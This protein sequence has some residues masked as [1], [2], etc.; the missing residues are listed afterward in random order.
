MKQMLF[1]FSLREMR[2]GFRTDSVETITVKK[3]T[4]RID[5]FDAN[6]FDTDATKIKKTDE[7]Y[8]EA[9]SVVTSVGVYPYLDSEG[10]VIMELRHPE[11]VYD[12]T[13]LETLKMLPI[14]ND[15]PNVAVIADNVKELSVG[16]AGENIGVDEKNGQITLPLKITDKD[17]VEDVSA[18]KQALSMGYSVDLEIKS[19]VWNGQHYDARQRNIRYNH[20]AIVERGR[21]GD[22]AILKMDICDAVLTKAK[23]NKKD[24][25]TIPTKE[26]VNEKMKKINLDGI[27]YDAEPE[28][29]AALVAANKRADEAEAATET[30]EAGKVEAEAKVETV[31]TEK[32]AVEE[33]KSTIEGER[34][35]L[36][37]AA[38]K[39]A[40]ETPENV[41][42]LIEE[43]LLLREN[44]GKA[45]VE[46]KDADDK[47]KSDAEL[48]REIILKVLPSAEKKMDE[49]KD[50]AAYIES[51]FDTA[52]ETLSEQKDNLDENLTKVN[53]TINKD[54]KDET[55]ETKYNTRLEDAWKTDKK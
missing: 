37:E 18:G 34:D 54:D 5:F 7:G 39:T 26:G 48:K 42:A 10:D 13:S 6:F 41:D 22:D 40:K 19:G 17:A 25:I 33:E 36:K 44:A 35:T 20:V 9:R 8:I 47:I 45:G 51:R 14:T 28:V 12:S 31:E 4:S 15:H 24:D 21:A 23:P 43:K 11:D 32:K 16:Y 55:P 46:L 49:K 2:S 50:D 1:G 3:E 27:I 30:A 53:Q 52:I 38:D 29:A